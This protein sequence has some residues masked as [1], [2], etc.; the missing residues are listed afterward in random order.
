MSE[1]CYFTGD[2]KL[3]PKHIFCYNIVKR[4]HRIQIEQAVV[5]EKTKL[6][7]SLTGIFIPLFC[8]SNAVFQRQTNMYYR[9]I[10]CSI[11]VW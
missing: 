10:L 9:D 3:T 2:V 5:V 7:T 8:V 4:Q 11:T 6:R 1:C